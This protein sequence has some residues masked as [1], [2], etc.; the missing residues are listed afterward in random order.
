[1]EGARVIIQ[2]ERLYFYGQAILDMVKIAKQDVELWDSP[3]R[4]GIVTGSSILA[5]LM[6]FLGVDCLTDPLQPWIAKTLYTN[7]HPTRKVRDFF[8]MGR[9]LAKIVLQRLHRLQRLQKLDR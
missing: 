7:I 8:D 2:P 9:R 4:P 5:G 3:L 6:F 1:M